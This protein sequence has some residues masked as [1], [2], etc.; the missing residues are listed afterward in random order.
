MFFRLVHISDLHFGDR[1]FTPWWALST[2]IPGLETHS[3]QVARE[4]SN[5]FRSGALSGHQGTVAVVA[6]GDL[7]TW[8]QPAAFTLV[9]TYLRSRHAIGAKAWMGFNQDDAA[10]VPGNH[11]I[12]SGIILGLSLSAPTPPSTRVDFDNYFNPP[13]LKASFPSTA[14]ALFPYQIPFACGPVTIYLYGLDSTRVDLLPNP[15]SHNFRAEGFV[16]RQQLED[17]EKF[18]NNEPDNLRIRIAAIHHP[19]GYPSTT[20]T[21]TWQT[22]VNLDDEVIPKLQDLGFVI[23]LCGHQHKGFVRQNGSV[24]S[25]N[26]PIWV[27]SAG[28]ATQTVRLSRREK[29]LLG[30]LP[31]KLS[32]ADQASRKLAVEKCNDYRVYD[33][34]LDLGTGSLQVDVRPHRF[35][36]NL[37]AFVSEPT[38]SISLRV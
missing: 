37:F 22:L 36:P 21:P 34:N 27:F 23:A 15:R 7:T 8:G 1:L 31:G 24:N 9:H 10:V 26:P 14:G 17:L 32:A 29:W 11:D 25:T 30:Q 2:W 6:T 38:T 19:I 16:D 33:F 4:L 20:G 5:S 3:A 12:W 13:A 28:T 35:D 18:V